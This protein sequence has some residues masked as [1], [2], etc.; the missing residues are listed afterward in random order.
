MSDT[1]Y[2]FHCVWR[3]HAWE[4][5][6]GARGRE[7]EEGC[8]GENKKQNLVEMGWEGQNISRMMK[9]LVKQPFRNNKATTRNKI[10]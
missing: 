10:T 3:F 2:T 1:V 4:V 6:G 9:N 7:Q 8:R 5:E